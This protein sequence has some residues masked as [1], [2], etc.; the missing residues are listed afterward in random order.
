MAFLITGIQ[1][2]VLLP[3]DLELLQHP[4][5]AG[6]ILFTRNYESLTQLKILTASIQAVKPSLFIAVDQEGG[7]VQRFRDGF[8]LLKSMRSFGELYKTDPEKAKTELKKQ[9]AIMATEL[10]SVGI[11]INLMPVLDVDHGISKVIGSR[12]LSDDPESVSVL[13]SLIVE[14]LHA[15]GLPA[16]AKHFPG[17]GGVAADSHYELP[18]DTRDFLAL[19][20]QDLQPFIK[21]IPQLDAIMPSHVVYSYCDAKPAG[22]SRYWLQDILRNQLSF[23]GVVISDD[24]GMAAATSGGNMVERARLALEAGCDLLILGNDLLAAK[25]VLGASLNELQSKDSQRRV[26]QFQAKADTTDC[27]EKVSWHT[28]NN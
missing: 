22:F 21:L 23:E 14:T 16:I 8:T 18:T 24:L 9:M 13:G 26:Q 25:E 3:E 1:G 20:Q 7:S 12:S 28:L 19:Q 11:T 6:V 10:K 4:Q 27:A 2:L 17:H 15:H 5:T